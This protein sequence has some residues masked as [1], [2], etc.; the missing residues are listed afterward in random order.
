MTAAVR[1]STGMR[2]SART[3]SSLRI[4]RVATTWRLDDFMG[5]EASRIFAVQQEAR[6]QGTGPRAQKSRGLARGCR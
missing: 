1:T 3:S 4:T 2:G 6:A 5:Q